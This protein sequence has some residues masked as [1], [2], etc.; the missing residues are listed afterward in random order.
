MMNGSGA[1]NAAG[2]SRR[3][4]C[5]NLS[6]GMIMPGGIIANVGSVS[7]RLPIKDN[8]YTGEKNI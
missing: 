8:V 1:I 7:I 5:V 6:S 2:S 3:G 4:L